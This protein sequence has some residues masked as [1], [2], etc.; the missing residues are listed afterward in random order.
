MFFFYISTYFGPWTQRLIVLEL[1]CGS[2]VD[3]LSRLWETLDSAHTHTHTYP[4]PSLASED[5][6]KVPST[7]P[8]GHSLCVEWRWVGKVLQSAQSSLPCSGPGS[9]W[10]G[11]VAL[12]HGWRTA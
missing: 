7:W 2:V 4:I 5:S 3:G 1:G 10:S 11:F 12:S 6:L 8:S 9:Y